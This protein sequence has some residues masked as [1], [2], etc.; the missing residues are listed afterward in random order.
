MPEDR[1]RQGLVLAMSV[2]ANATLAILERLARLSF[3][4]RRRERAGRAAI[5][6]P[7]ARAR[8]RG[9]TRRSPALS[10][11]NQQKIVLAQWLAARAAC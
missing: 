3:V 9:S 6:R 1:K 4:D 11:G 5:L 7:A 10:G 2:L 8:R